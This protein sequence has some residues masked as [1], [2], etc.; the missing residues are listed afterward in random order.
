M[1]KLRTDEGIEYKTANPDDSPKVLIMIPFI[2]VS[3]QHMTKV[4]I[5]I[6]FKL[7]LRNFPDQL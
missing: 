5:Q 6:A 1:K 4:D 3:Y 2:R 7:A